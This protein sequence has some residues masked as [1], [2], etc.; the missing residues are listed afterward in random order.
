MVRGRLP[1]EE[2]GGQCR[3]TEEAGNFIVY[4][5]LTVENSIY[6]RAFFSK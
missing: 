6:V 3:S 2:M 4:L 5:F 1:G